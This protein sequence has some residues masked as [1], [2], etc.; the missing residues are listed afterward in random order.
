MKNLNL[1]MFI[2]L[3]LAFTLT[4]CGDD[5]DPAPTSNVTPTVFQ[6]ATDLQDNPAIRISDFGAGVGTRTFD[7]DTVYI[8]SGFV[9]V[10]EGQTLTIEPGTVIKG[11]PG[12][13]VAASALI[14]A[15]GATIIANGTAAAPIIMTAF[16]DD[17]D[18]VD[19]SDNVTATS[20]GLWGGLIVLGDAPINH[21]NSETNIE[22]IP[23]TE[24]RALYG[25]SNVAHNGG[26][27][28]YISLR[29]GATNIGAGNEINGLTM[30]GV[31]NA[32]IFSYIETFAFD[33]DGFEWFGGTANSDHLASIYNQDDSF[34][35]DFGW[36]GENQFWVSYQEPGFTG[37]D[38]GFESDGAHSGNLT[39]AVFSKPQ[40]YNATVIGQ[41]NTGNND[42]CLFFTEGSGVLLH[43]SIVMN[44]ARGINLTED[45]AEGNTS[46]NRLTSGDAVFKNNIFFNI[47]ANAT[48]IA[49]VASPDG[50]TTAYTAFET[51]LTDND[52]EVGNPGV[53]SVAVNNFNPLLNAG[54]LGTTKTRSALPSASVNGFTYTTANYIGAFGT[55]G[56]WLTGWT[57]A[58]AY[59]IL[60]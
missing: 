24:T 38:R 34:D 18:V 47:G 6:Q 50:G 42:N 4:S 40:I 8:L 22:G 12:S 14:V 51:H 52:N 20:R 25:G 10:N 41:G 39:A 60:D 7:K 58:D 11:E 2:I 5:N 45:G 53:G 3:G 30:G 19:G 37:S 28:K 59:G 46:R 55:S 49:Y 31:G 29:H 26:S 15:K 23:T 57:A 56:N 43:N 13:G 36:R 1:L 17:V 33:D 35:W 16:A 21:A 44:F 27:L 48:T 32:T 9:F 54:S